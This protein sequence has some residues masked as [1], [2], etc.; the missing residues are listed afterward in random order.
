MPLYFFHLS[1][2]DRTHTDGEGFEFPSRSAARAEA[3][4]VIRDLSH[5]AE[6]TPRR[7]AGWSLCVADA[8]GQFLS[9]PIGEPALAVVS[10]RPQSESPTEPA[11][12]ARMAELAQLIS[13]CIQR[14]RHLLE[15]N[16]KLRQEFE[17]EFARSRQLSLR[18]REIVSSARV[19]GWQSLD[20]TDVKAG[21][22]RCVRFRPHLIVLPGGR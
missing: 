10:D 3:L 17:S 12:E 7:W 6:R 13:E 1:C 4:A 14:A 15:E 22:P 20:P 11:V 21:T 16:Q 5:G 9:L 18:S 19:V 8:E 2:G